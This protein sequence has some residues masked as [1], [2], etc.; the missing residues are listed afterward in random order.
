M[1]IDFAHL[2]KYTLNDRALEAEILGLFVSQ[3]PE[4]LARL[5]DAET[6]A[7]WRAAAHTIKGSARAVGAGS[8]A[9]AAAAA[10]VLREE[11]SGRR[12]AITLI[13]D[14]V[15]RAITFVADVGGERP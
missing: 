4:S 11:D 1:P 3:L 10:E 6:Q 9:E 8:L 14:E 15:S 12:E 2:A 5:R 13:S 7:E